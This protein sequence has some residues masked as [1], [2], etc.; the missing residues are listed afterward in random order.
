MDFI[1]ELPPSE[2]FTTIF[3]IVNCFSKMAHFIPL[4]G[5]PST[6]ETASAFIK[7]VVRLHGIPTS[8]ISDRGVQFQALCEA[9]NFVYLLLTIHRQMD[10]PRGQTKLSNNILD[11]FRPSR[12]TIG[13]SSFLWQSLRTITW[14]LL[15]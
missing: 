14:F 1:V 3:V 8:I 5:T 11:V 9:L 13:C 4:K 10:R 15:P 2:G 6:S 7:E 12:K